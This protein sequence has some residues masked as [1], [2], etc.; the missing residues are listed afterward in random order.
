M[1]DP[2]LI[3]ETQQDAQGE[4]ATGA[5]ALPTT[6]LPLSKG[7]EGTPTHPTPVPSSLVRQNAVLLRDVFTT[8]ATPSSPV[9]FD[10]PKSRTASRTK[11]STANDVEV[12]KPKPSRTVRKKKATV[13]KLPDVVEWVDLTA[14]EPPLTPSPR[15][16]NDT[17]PHLN[18]LPRFP[19]PEETSWTTFTRV[20]PGICDITVSFNNSYCTNSYMHRITDDFLQVFT[21]DHLG[22]GR[23]LEPTWN[24]L[25]FS[26]YRHPQ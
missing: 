13:K 12:V 8:S 1:S 15:P 6:P 11:N 3:P 7:Y 19:T 10:Y 22:A 21:W 23:P 14:P 18:S 4:D 24:G 26:A 20:L 9:L 5:G 25:T 2:C 16:M 17:V